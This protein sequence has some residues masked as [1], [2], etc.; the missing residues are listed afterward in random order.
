[1]SN[2]NHPNAKHGGCGTR[3]YS[4]WKQMRIRCYCKSNPTYR[5]YGERGIG[6][7]EEWHDFDNFKKWAMANG[8]ADNLTIDRKDADKDY[9]PENCCWITKG[10]N[11]KNKRTTKFYEHNGIKM[12]HNDWARK[13]GINPSTLTGRIKRHGIQKALEMGGNLSGSIA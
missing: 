7:C 6:I 3:L 4:I 9:S 11:S 5:F 13:F 1:M 12:C 2:I 10:E 8:Y